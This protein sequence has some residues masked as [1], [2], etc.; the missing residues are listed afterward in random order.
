MR[1]ATPAT[2]WT[3][4]RLIEVSYARPVTRN[5]IILGVVAFVLVV[6]SL[7]VALVVPRRDP[8][9][10]GKNLRLFVV[11]AVLLVAGMLTAVEVFGGE[12][13]A[14]EGEGGEQTMTETG[15]TDTGRTETGAPE[16]DPAAGE[17]VF[18]SVAQPPCGSCHT[19]Q[20]AGA[21]QT[22]GPNLDDV[23]TGKDAQ[24]IS[25]SIVNPDAE[26]AQGFSADLMPDT[27]GEQLSDDE[28]ANL[29]A[30]LVQSTQ[31]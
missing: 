26:V 1:R 15:A 31:Q 24:F 29:V 18:T 9:F 7:V 17:Q 22:L 16:G 13:E 3:P 11:V 10:P 8:G 14:R 28:L 25:E 23:L 27:Y 12:H 2:R 21:T 20:A 5:E 4:T 19:L 6:F 30:F